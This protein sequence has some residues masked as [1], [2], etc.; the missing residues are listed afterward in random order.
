[1]SSVPAI[2]G[3]PPGVQFR[4]DADEL[5]DLYLLPRALG[6]PA[7]F[8]GIAVLDDDAAG[9]TMPEELLERH[10]RAGD[11]DAYFFVCSSGSCGGGGAATK[12]GARQD[13]S[14]GGG[15]GTW[16]SQKRVV[17]KGHYCWK[18]SLSYKHNLNLHTGRGESGG[19]VGWV[20]HEYALTD[21]SFP[22]LKLCHV[23][24]SG[25]GKNS[26]R[27][28]G[29]DGQ[30]SEPAPTKRARLDAGG[31]ASS[32]GSGESTMTTVHEDYYSET[33]QVDLTGGQEATDWIDGLS[34]DALQ[35]MAYFAAP[36]YGEPC[37]FDGH[38]VQA[39]APAALQ[40]VPEHFMV[41]DT[42]GMAGLEH[43]P[44]GSSGSGGSTTMTTTDQDYY[45]SGMG[46]GSADHHGAPPAPQAALT[47]QEATDWIDDFLRDGL[48]EM[49][50][51]APAD[52]EHCCLKEQVVVEAAVPATEQ[53]QAPH[54]FVPMVQET[55]GMVELD[56]RQQEFL[57]PT[58]VTVDEFGDVSG[59]EASATWTYAEAQPTGD[60]VTWEGYEFC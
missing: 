35:G 6:D 21:P 12:P 49:A 15:A 23:S 60:V 52:T 40:Q 38:V 3:L 50:F 53:P 51:A 10:D 45:Y 16:K 42:A 33:A 55:A 1:M 59:A 8:H 25:H 5:V 11:L 26:K 28:P 22:P 30:I 56:H 41:Q 46:P 7:P 9:S 43:P 13:R 44:T 54:H 58:G 18:Y 39:S 29:P 14:C 48:P 19:S 57:A 36:V 27:V 32:S 4:P 24:F 34:S 31:S 37:C 17:E 47:G 20:M 2:L